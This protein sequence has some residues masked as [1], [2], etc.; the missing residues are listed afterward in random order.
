[1]IPP[2]EDDLASVT[3][4]LGRAPRGRWSVARR[5]A[6][7]KPQ[8]LQTE[9]RLDDGTPFPT[10]YWLTCR[11]LSSAIG[12]L[13]SSGWMAGL[14][15]RLAEDP[16]FHARLAAA[17]EDYVRRRDALDPLGPTSH[18]GGGPDRV[19]CLHAHTAH[20]LVTGDNPAGAE[21]LAALEW[22]DPQEPCV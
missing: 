5:C 12:G 9:P 2:P 20:F 1:L 21:A 14:N 15:R 3:A 6:C 18:P 8:V 11:K 4:Q 13:E 22:E 17:T 16:G 7:G 10:L 19:K